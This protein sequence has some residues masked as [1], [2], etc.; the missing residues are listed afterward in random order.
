MAQP[1]PLHEI[2][3]Q[4]GAVFTA[5]AGWSMPTR[6]GDPLAERRQA[7]TSAA[8]FDVSNRGKVEV[9]GKDAPSFLHNLCTNDVANLPLGA[10]CEAFFCTN[11]AKVVAHALVYHLRLAGNRDAFWL[12]VAPGEDEKLIKHLDRYI[13][14]EQVELAHRTTG[15]AQVHLAGPTAKQ[16]LSRALA[17]DVPDLEPLMHM[18]RTFGVNVHAHIRCNDM[19][20][21]PGYDIVCLKELAPGLWR[22]LTGAG[23]KPAGLEAFEI[24]RVEAGT[25]VYGVDIDENRFAFEIGR[26]SQAISYSKGCYLGQ[27]PIVMARDRAGHAPRTLT[28]LRLT[29]PEPAAS[30]AKVQHGG[31]EVGWVT[32]S[33]PSPRLGAPIALAY[34]RYGHQ[35]P[36]TKVEV[37][38][39]GPAIVTRLPFD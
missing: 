1:S 35:E 17:D 19:L 23:A 36:G 18:E 30:G 2:T 38:G 33:V 5:Q 10:G 12:D 15:F 3:E 6:F 13:I 22:M 20:G 4:A 14:A 16:V 24:L 7:M 25:P 34:L 11:R 21:V 31:E 26:T 28:G 29:G 8:I 39:N 37:E 32:S 27:E 9:T